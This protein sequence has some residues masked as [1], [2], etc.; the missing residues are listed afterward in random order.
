MRKLLLA[1]CA[2]LLVAAT[3]KGPSDTL[4]IAAIGPAAGPCAPLGASAAP[5]EKAY[6][7]H[8]AARLGMKVLT[9][10]RPPRPWRPA[11]STWLC[12][13]PRASPRLRASPGPS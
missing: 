10:P 4:R 11:N 7:E 9:C 2:V 13:I 5:G 6:Y 8:L 12:W 1:A 3:A